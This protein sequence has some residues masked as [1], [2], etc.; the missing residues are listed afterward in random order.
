MILRFFTFL[1][2][3]FMPAIA[4]AEWNRASSDHFII[5][6]ETSSER[7]R[8]FTE[9]V[10][11]FDALMRIMTGQGKETSPNKLVIFVVRD[12]AT[13]QRLIG[14]AAGSVA[15]FYSPSIA[16]SIAVVPKSSGS[17]GSRGDHDAEIILFHEYAHHFMLQYF[18]AGYPAWYVEGYAEYYSTTEFRKDGSIAVGMPAQHRA[19]SLLLLPAYPLTKMFSADAGKMTND[20][21][22]SFYG[23]SW[24]LTHYLRFEPS[25]KG[26]LT[27]YIN[28]FAA[29]VPAEKAARDAFGD[30][31]KLQADLKRY[32]Q[33]S[34]MTYQHLSGVVLPVPTIDITPVSPTEAVLMPLYMRFMNGAHGQAEVD[35]FVA[36]AR[37]AA[38]RF[39]GEPR[40]ME[41][42]AEGELD[43]EQFDAATKA[44]D[45]LL[46]QR[47]TDARALLRRAR[48][49][50]AIMRDTDKYP[51]G[52]KAI[53]SLIVKAN[54]ASPDDPFPLSEYFT[55]FPS[56]GIQP[57]PIAADGLIRALEL[58]PQVPNLRFALAQWLI[59][60]NRRDQA[61]NVLAPLL[62]EPHSPAMR[63]T[64]REMVDPSGP[65]ILPV[66][67]SEDKNGKS[68]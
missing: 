67:D 63:E 43:A 33:A 57:T 68:K 5:Y 31:A 64:A 23:H 45:A 58:A 48:I 39:P 4:R 11:K 50:T 32:L 62:N 61:R 25:R 40:A 19:T 42:L 47:P 60:S 52:W 36:A 66:K 14:K 12:I 44:N 21:S 10:E 16:G 29:G 35:S 9:R 2:M 65:A 24:L 49:A 59:R 27:A 8:G 18:A 6:G 1:L 55:S 30:V 28:A 17:E 15:G 34:K 7:L 46:V 41:L 53:R 26:Q 38:A 51:G 20:E 13:V 56:E 22:A 3:I 37:I 54:R